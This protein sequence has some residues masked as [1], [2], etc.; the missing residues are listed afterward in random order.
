MVCDKGYIW[1]SSNC[2]CECN[3]P[4]GICQ[5]LH[6]K[7]CVCRNSLVDKL[8]E[9][10]TNVIDGNTIYNKKLAASSSNDCAS[11]TPYIILFAVFLS[12]IVIIIFIVT[13]INN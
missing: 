13:E 2:A 1:N 5:Y 6:Y 4:C 3:K 10:C 8:V 11:C 9:E 12:M 7:S